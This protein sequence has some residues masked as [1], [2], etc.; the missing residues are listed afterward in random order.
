MIGRDILLLYCIGILF[1]HSSDDTEKKKMNGYKYGFCVMRIAF[2]TLRMIS[3]VMVV[4]VVW[5]RLPV[6]VVLITITPMPETIML[7]T[8]LDAAFSRKI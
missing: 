2:D 5:Q 1:R 3:M 8:T 6:A 7:T 4:V